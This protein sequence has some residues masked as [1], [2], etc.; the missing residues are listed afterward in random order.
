[1]TTIRLEEPVIKY[2]INTPGLACPLKWPPA[3]ASIKLKHL[4][5]LILA[6]KFSFLG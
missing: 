5:K 3:P 2:T 1:M 4:F 6:R